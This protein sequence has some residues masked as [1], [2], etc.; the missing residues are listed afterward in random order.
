MKKIVLV[1][2]LLVADV[3]LSAEPSLANVAKDAATQFGGSG[4]EWSWHNSPWAMLLGA[5]IVIYMAFQLYH[6]FPP[7]AYALGAVGVFFLANAV[8]I[9]GNFYGTNPRGDVNIF[10]YQNPYYISQH[11]HDRLWRLYWKFNEA[12][13]NSNTCTTSVGKAYQDCRLNNN[14]RGVMVEVY[15]ERR[16]E[17]AADP[18]AFSKFKPCKDY[19]INS[20]AKCW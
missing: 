20:W 11:E 2:V 14:C 8:G 6:L 19:T 4:K 7:A 16:R 1:G 18:S 13:G 15:N 3:L 5:A 12:C 17:L 9:V 10:T